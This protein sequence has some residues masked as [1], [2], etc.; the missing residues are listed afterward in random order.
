MSTSDNHASYFAWHHGEGPD[1]VLAAERFG[2]INQLAQ[3]VI[4]VGDVECLDLRRSRQSMGAF[5]LN[6]P[7]GFVVSGVERNKEM[8]S[9]RP[10]DWGC[11]MPSASHS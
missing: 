11:A 8:V 1:V 3:R 7:A 9:P 10:F 5:A 6:R 2:G 4:R